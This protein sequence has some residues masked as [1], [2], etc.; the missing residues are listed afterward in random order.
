MKDFV[1]YVWIM[2]SFEI[3]QYEMKFLSPVSNNER[4]FA[5]TSMASARINMPNDANALKRYRKG[6]TRKRAVAKKKQA[7][8]KSTEGAALSSEHIYA[9]SLEPSPQKKRQRKNPPVDK[10]KRVGLSRV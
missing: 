5:V 1:S 4:R 3:L 10:G 2:R 9:S 8:G 6:L 7:A